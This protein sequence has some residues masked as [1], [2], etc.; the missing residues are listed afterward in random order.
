MLGFTWLLTHADGY[1]R[2]YGDPAIVK[3]IVFPRQPDITVEMMA[4]YIRMVGNWTGYSVRSRGMKTYL[5]FPNFGKHQVVAFE[6]LTKKVGQI[7]QKIR[8]VPEKSE[9]SGVF[10]AK[11]R[12]SRIKLKKK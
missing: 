9:T 7:F 4:E 6:D 5:E 11:N 12:L 8:Q 10:P 1:G 3:A 2:T